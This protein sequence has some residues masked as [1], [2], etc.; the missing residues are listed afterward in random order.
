MSAK[1]FIK[2]TIAAAALCSC[3]IAEPARPKDSSLLASFDFEATDAHAAWKETRGK[4]VPPSVV[5]LDADRPHSGRSALKF[6]ATS[7]GKTSRYV[8][9]G[10]SLPA[11]H[12]KRV[13]VRCYVRTTG[14]QDGDGEIN[15][16]A[17]DASRVIGWCGG[18]A[19][20][21]SIGNVGDWKEFSAEV[22]LQAEARVLT[23]FIRIQ[24]PAAGK[25][26]W[27]DDLSIESADE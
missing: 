20:L 5:V 22:P 27:V 2:S 13:R 26:I 17:R 21:A 9:A 15:L 19:A 18:K 4:D 12:P 24:N 25:T 1:R 6:Q 14:L 23:L 16:L 3:V 10:V 8:F 7:E 11:E